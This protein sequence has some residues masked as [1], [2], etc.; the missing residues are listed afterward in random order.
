MARARS[1]PTCR[2]IGQ[3]LEIDIKGVPHLCT[4]VW[5]TDFGTDY[6]YPGPP[7]A[8]SHITV[9]SPTVRHS[10]S[11]VR[12]LADG[13]RHIE[14]N[15]QREGSGPGSRFEGKLLEDVQA[16]WVLRELLAREGNWNIPGRMGD[17]K[18]RIRILARLPLPLLPAGMRVLGVSDGQFSLSCVDHGQVTVHSTCS[19]RTLSFEARRH[20]REQHG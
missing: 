2:S 7:R 12:D 6:P 16:E 13:I 15:Y 11:L 18:P 20:W 10:D 8:P 17:G 9:S 5:H 3:P 1:C 4:D 14:Y 19:I